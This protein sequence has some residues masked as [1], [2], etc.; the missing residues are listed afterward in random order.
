VL[1]DMP[2]EP[3]AGPPHAAQ[4]DGETGR[5]GDLTRVGP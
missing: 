3:H 1:G 4:P 5:S 2:A